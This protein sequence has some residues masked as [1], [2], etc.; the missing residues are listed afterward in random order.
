MTAVPRDTKR[1]I[2][3][4]AEAMI[5]E[6][7]YNAFSYQHIAEQLGV[8][9]AAIHYHFRSKA[10][11]GVAVIERYRRRFARWAERLE[12]EE[13]DPWRKLEAFFGI[14]L[15]FKMHGGRVCPSGVLQAEYH[16]ISEEMQASASGLII[17]LQRWLTRILAEGREQG[18]FQFPGEPADQALVVG[19]T[20][21]G[22]LQ[23]ARAWGPER[24][25]AAL[26]QLRRQL[27]P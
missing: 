19:A 8:K 26:D 3:D 4:A 2:L 7:G 1:E 9:N 22:A 14:Y 21:Q 25:D 6:R 24:F 12:A 23:I 13:R 10:D 16:S 18:V 5:Q 17:D 27:R 20:L 15:D 11:L